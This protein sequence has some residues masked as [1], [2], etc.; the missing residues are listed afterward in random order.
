MQST[1][2]NHLEKTYKILLFLATTTTTTMIPPNLLINPGAENQF[3][4]WT[5]MGPSTAII[6]SNGK[7]H[8]NYYPR[9][10]SNCFAGGRGV[11]PYSKLHQ[12]IDLVGGAQG[13]TPEKLDSGNLTAY[14][15]FYYQTWR[16]ELIGNDYPKV[17]VSIRNDSLDILGGIHTGELHCTPNPGWCHYS[18]AVRLPSGARTIFYVML[19]YERVH[20]GLSIDAYID[21]NS[22][23]IM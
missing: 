7:F 18:K 11:G 14:V 1:S 9:S 23:I 22:L 3:E 20:L 6:D 16:D 2:N 21:D 4:G 19:F 8:K 10:G 13:F 12:R 17:D 5:Q 15:S